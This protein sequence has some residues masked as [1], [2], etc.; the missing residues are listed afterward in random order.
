MPYIVQASMSQFGDN[1]NYD[2]H[3]FPTLAEALLHV[4]EQMLA[5]RGRMWEY[6]LP[7]YQTFMCLGAGGFGPADDRP[8]EAVTE[9]PEAD[10]T[11]LY[12]GSSHSN[13]ECWS[14]EV[15]KVP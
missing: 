8:I 11:T 1:T 10:S 9:L 14:F 6:I 5:I 7:K 3:E 12:F 4:Q 13:C 2:P 15:T